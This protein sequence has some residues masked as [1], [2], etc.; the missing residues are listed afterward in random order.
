MKSKDQVLLEQAYEQVR[1][2]QSTSNRKPAPE[3]E[4]I[5]HAMMAG[6]GARE[7]AKAGIVGKHVSVFEKGLKQSFAN[8]SDLPQ[9]EQDD[10][11][12]L[13][14]TGELTYD[15]PVIASG[16]VQDVL[17]QDANNDIRLVIN[18]TE[19]EKVVPFGLGRFLVISSK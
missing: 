2:N 11:E 13:H 1:S 8:K 19:G 9:D 18:T 3:G 15:G 4:A 17:W 5:H 7:R 6:P 12:R 14:S 16:T 10:G